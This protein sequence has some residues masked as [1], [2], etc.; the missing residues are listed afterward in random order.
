VS[1]MWSYPN[2]IPL[3]P[4]AIRQVAKALKPLK[5][6]RLYGAVPGQVVNSDASG[7]VARSAERYLK[8]IS[9]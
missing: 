3:G 2:L 5:F 6:D 1:F 8:M 7:A 4:A 9:G